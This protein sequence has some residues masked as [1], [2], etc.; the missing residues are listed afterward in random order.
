MLMLVCLQQKKPRMQQ[1]HVLYAG[2]WLGGPGRTVS[3][4]HCVRKLMQWEVQLLEE[5][6][7]DTDVSK[8]LGRCREDDPISVCCTTSLIESVLGDKSMRMCLELQPSTLACS[9]A[10]ER[11]TNDF[12][13]LEWRSCSTIMHKWLQGD[14]QLP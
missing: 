13:A 5:L 8:V 7:F 14:V 6:D 3:F 4:V 10:L 2:A 1:R 12:T 9:D 11:G